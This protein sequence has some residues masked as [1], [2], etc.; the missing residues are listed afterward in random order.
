MNGYRNFLQEQAKTVE[1]EPNQAIKQKIESSSAIQKIS[2]SNRALNENLKK[3]LEKKKN[4][5]AENFTLA[6]EID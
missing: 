3:I 6:R 1:L 4:L 5:E 2:E